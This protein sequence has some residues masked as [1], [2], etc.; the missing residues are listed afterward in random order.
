V[1]RRLKSEVKEEKKTVK[2]RYYSCDS[3]VICNTT[4]PY[5][6]A[7]DIWQHK[8][9]IKPTW[10]SNEFP[11]QN[12][13]S[14]IPAKKYLNHKPYLLQ[15][16]NADLEIVNQAFTINLFGPWRL[17]QLCIPIMKTNKYGRIVNVS[18]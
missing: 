4:I 2:N 10:L 14:L 16:I 1:S 5:I 18:S 6:K 7:S 11:N 13:K 12:Q 15:A 17:S 3:G 8:D 9:D